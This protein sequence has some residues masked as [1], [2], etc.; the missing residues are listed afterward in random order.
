MGNAKTI[1][2]KSESSKKKT[3]T[4]IVAFGMTEAVI[5]KRMAQLSKHVDKN[6]ATTTKN[7]LDVIDRGHDALSKQGNYGKIKI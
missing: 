1:K 3:A 4:K 6:H 7:F 2:R 5:E